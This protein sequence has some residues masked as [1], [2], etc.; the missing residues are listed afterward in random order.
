MNPFD[1]QEWKPTFC[2]TEE[3]LKAFWEEHQIARKRIMKINA[4]GIALN[5]QG[6]SLEERIKKTLSAAG[7]TVHLMQRMNKELYN[8]IQLNAELEL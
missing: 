8:N 4:I 1:I 2:K 7:V 6:W 5:M 3:E